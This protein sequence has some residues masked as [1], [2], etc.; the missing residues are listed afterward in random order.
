MDNA[1]GGK[2]RKFS[3]DF[4][5]ETLSIFHFSI[6]HYLNTASSTPLLIM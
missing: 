3:S 1:S 5:P 2:L 4:Q 6:I